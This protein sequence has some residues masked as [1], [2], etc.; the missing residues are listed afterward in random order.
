MILEKVR[1]LNFGPFYGQHDV[2]FNNNGIGVHV[3]RGG[4]GQ[5]K[6]SFHR[7][8]LWALHGNVVDR[9]GEAIPQTSLLNRHARRMDEYHFGVALFF[10]HED[11]DW[12]LHRETRAASH[13]EKKYLEGIRLS[14]VRD[15]KPIPD[16]QQEIERIL[17]HEVSRFH[18]FDGE[19][20]RDYEELLDK[21][22]S[23]MALLRDS[24]E[25]VLGVPHLRTARNDLNAV[26]KALERECSRL[27]R[28]LGDKDLKELAADISTII[29]D[30]EDKEK[31]VG[32]LE[33]NISE[34]QS[35]ISDKKRNLS[36]LK[37]VAALANERLEVEKDIEVLKSK[38]EKEQSSL[39]ERTKDLY[40]AVLVP[41]AGAVLT[42]LENRSNQSLEKFKKKQ[43][44][45]EKAKRLERDISAQIC[46]QCGSV[47]DRKKLE[48]L[49]EEMAETEI[50]IERFTE[51]PEPNLEFYH[52]KERLH[53]MREQAV[54]AQDFENIGSRIEEIDHKLAASEERLSQISDKLL[55]V[56]AEEPR[57]LEIEIREC[58]R[59]LGRLEEVVKKEIEEKVALEALK[60]ELESR[61]ASIPEREINILN[62][63][64]GYVESIKDVFES[65]ILTY[66]NRRKEEVEKIATDVFRE[67]RSKKSF[68]HLEINE[69]FGLSIV[70][71]SGD[72]LDKGEW[73]S[74]GEEQLVALALI[75]AL[76]RCTQAKA[77][78]MMDTPF[79]RLDTEHGERVLRFISDLGTQVILLVTDREFRPGDEKLLSTGPET[80][81]TIHFMEEEECSHI[82]PSTMEDVHE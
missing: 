48:R 8:I 24:V 56:D 26:Q 43:S 6:T 19:M 65:S 63:R 35:E 54:K 21:D 55:D 51:V 77:P 78:V 67:I 70:T 29:D 61:R 39:Q 42:E 9:K 30:I 4:T 60:G 74:S 22:S 71:R 33:S 79:A 10:R 27:M 11:A 1:M 36:D 66:R 72:S 58:N 38:R 64:I 44:A 5:G 50:Q 52:Y 47:L 34:L 32:E 28:R 17:P 31:T 82:A 80:D 62:E 76:N 16:P 12:A 81:L 3:I 46:G 20:L 75:G 53:E 23:S 7:A 13:R 45:V 41:K 18:F 49:K 73:R 25:R 57:R 37:E 69:Q 2:E 14:L 68:D 15:G 59:E 40:K